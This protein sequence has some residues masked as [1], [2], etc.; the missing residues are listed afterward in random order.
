MGIGIELGAFIAWTIIDIYLGFPIPFKP[1]LF[2]VTIDLILCYFMICCYDMGGNG[3][4]D[5]DDNNKIGNGNGKRSKDSN[6]DD[7][8]DDD[9][10]DDYS[11]SDSDDD[12]RDS[13]LTSSLSW[14]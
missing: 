7:N 2:T 14:C 1:I 10:D 4:N 6:T 13:S 12:D 9:S 8:D 3:N 5:N 11:D